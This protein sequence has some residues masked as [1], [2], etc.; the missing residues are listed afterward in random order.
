MGEV[1]VMPDRG[2][3]RQRTVELNDAAGT[4]RAAA[5]RERINNREKPSKTVCRRISNNLYA[6]L[7]SCPVSAALVLKEAGIVGDS[8]K[9]LKRYALPPGRPDGEMVRAPLPRL[10]IVDAIARL[11]DQNPDT[12]VLQV[13]GEWLPTEPL[14]SMPS[15]AEPTIEADLADQVNL[16]AN[17]VAEAHNLSTAFRAISEYR[18]FLS[19]AFELEMDNCIDWH[20]VWHNFS[21]G[22]SIVYFW[23]DMDVLGRD[24]PFFLPYPNVLLGRTDLRETPWSDPWDLGPREFLKGEDP[25]TLYAGDAYAEIRLAVLPIGVGQAPEA[26]FLTRVIWS[27]QKADPDENGDGWEPWAHLSSCGGFL[28]YIPGLDSNTMMSEE[29]L[30]RWR[31]I[32]DGLIGNQPYLSFAHDR[33]FYTPSEERVRLAVYDFPTAD[34]TRID[35]VTPESCGRLLS[36]ISCGPSGTDMLG[37][38]MYASPSRYVFR[39]APDFADDRRAAADWRHSSDDI[40]C[41]LSSETSYWKYQYHALGGGSTRFVGQSRS[42]YGSILQTLERSIYCEGPARLD[43]VLDKVCQSFAQPIHRFAG[44]Q[45][46]ERERIRQTLKHRWLSKS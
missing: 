9:R 21:P 36:R 35:R 23:D 41:D 19:G 18:I 39:A 3:A 1:I 32:S 16:I 40:G 25:A 20:S 14:L 6:L 33:D 44:E 42:C 7:E 8:T 5:I 45:W 26:A 24:E 29:D 10:R 12:L 22:S 28:P 13:F 31:Q 2:A 11:T 15:I 27:V 30:S 43:H 4:S 17:G 37:G 38:L 46:A 34:C